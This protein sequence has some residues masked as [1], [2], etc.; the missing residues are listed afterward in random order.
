MERRSGRRG[1]WVG[2][3]ARALEG[4]DW[5]GVGA[6]VVVGTWMRTETLAGGWA[7]DG[8]RGLR[9]EWGSRWG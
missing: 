7:E 8:A 4:N 2:D 9:L 1:S 5:V 6:D 3:R